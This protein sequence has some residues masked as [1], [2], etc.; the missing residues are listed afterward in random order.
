MELDGGSEG[1]DRAG[2]DNQ[3]SRDRIW[4]LTPLHSRRVSGQ[5]SHS[6]MADSL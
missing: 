1:D 5:F 6:V 2:K 4:V 3:Q